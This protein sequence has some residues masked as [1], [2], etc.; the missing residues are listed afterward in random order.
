MTRLRPRLRPLRHQE[1]GFLRSRRNHQRYRLSIG[2]SPLLRFR[3][4]PLRTPTVTRE[5]RLRQ[6][7]KLSSSFNQIPISSI[8]IVNCNGCFGYW[9]QHLVLLARLFQPRVLFAAIIARLAP[10]TL[11]STSTPIACLP[12]NAT[13][14]I[15]REG[16]CRDTPYDTTE[17]KQMAMSYRWNSMAKLL[18]ISWRTR[19]IFVLQNI[20]L[21][22]SELTTEFTSLSHCT[23]LVP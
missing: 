6:I 4:L 5:G 3:P 19:S 8:V 15:R 14:P 13:S 23:F 11:A 18:E 2:C 12:S 22:P 20:A 7:V 10:A 17:Y 9:L 1:R 16:E 21:Q